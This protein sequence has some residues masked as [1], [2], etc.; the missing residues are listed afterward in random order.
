MGIGPLLFILR[1][2]G[3]LEDV[4]GLNRVPLRGILGGLLFKGSTRFHV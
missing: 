4:R 2:K 1:V 3:V